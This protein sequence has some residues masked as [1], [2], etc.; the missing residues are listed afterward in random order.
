MNYVDTIRP[1][2]AFN[3][4][5]QAFLSTVDPYTEYYD[6]DSRAELTKMTTGEYDYAGIGSFIM[7]RDSMSYISAPIEGTPSAKAGLR[8]GDHIIR[9]DSTDT[10]RMTS[11]AIKKLL[12]G[13]AGSSVNVTVCRP[14]VTDSILTFNIV[15]SKFSEPSV[16]YWDVVNGNTGY[17]R[18]TQFIANSG[19][20]VREALEAF[21]KNPKVDK[22]VLDLRG[23]GGGLLEAAVDILGNFVPKGT[24]CS[25]PVERTPLPKRSTRPRAL[26]SSPT[27][28]LLCSLMEVQPRR[29]KSLP[30]HCR[31]LTVLYSSAREVSVRDWCRALFL[32]LTTGC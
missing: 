24:K 1:K 14:Y 23:N 17:I 26:H 2:E 29:L 5:I 18:L 10:Y 11:D 22:I 6:S 12:R 9:V 27:Y 7:Q 4:A 8:S 19:K 16:P 28:R 15:R 13:E 32:S 20:D 31:I 3:S 21:K 25:A 30:A